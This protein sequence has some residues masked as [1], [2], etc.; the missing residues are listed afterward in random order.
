MS[1]TNRGWKILCQEDRCMRVYVEAEDDDLQEMNLLVRILKYARVR[2]LL[3]YMTGGAAGGWLSERAESAAWPTHP[4]DNSWIRRLWR[5]ELCL[6]RPYRTPTLSI[7]RRSH[8]H[9]ST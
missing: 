2:S 5:T 7:I 8:G 1:P 3:L 6:N 9:M 4:R